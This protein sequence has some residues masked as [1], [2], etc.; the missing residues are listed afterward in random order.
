MKGAVEDF[1]EV[2]HIVSSQHSLKCSNCG[3]VTMITSFSPA[4]TQRLWDVAT[5]IFLDQEGDQTSSCSEQGGLGR[6]R[7]ALSG[8][9]NMRQ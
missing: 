4:A 7:R 8:Q 5:P 9:G 3:T 1:P 2:M 6:G